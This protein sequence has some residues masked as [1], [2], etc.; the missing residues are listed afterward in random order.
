MRD[1]YGVDTS[2][3]MHARVEIRET[4]DVAPEA[5]LELFR[6]AA[7]VRHS[8]RESAEAAL[9]QTSLLLTA[10]HG[11]RCVAMLRV[12][13]DGM[14]RAL[15]ED[16]IVHPDYRGRGY[17]RRLI[18]AALTHPRVRE[19]EGA[20]L[21]TDLPAFYERFGFRRVATGMTRGRPPRG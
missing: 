11:D 1:G 21:F 15:I 18:E 12:L 3:Q 14:Y 7:W 4:P 16:V 10:W 19:V 13:S 20:F 17:G 9:A 2:D 6:Y 8:T 5:L